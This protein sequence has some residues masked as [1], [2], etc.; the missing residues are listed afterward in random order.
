MSV[1]FEVYYPPPTDPRRE[2]EWRAVA[3]RHGGRLDF[4]EDDTARTGICLSYEFDDWAAAES[5]AA[6][7]RRH[8][9]HV[10]GP[11]EYAD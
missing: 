1:M 4:R 3:E 6:D 10:E 2:A 5:A 7:L 8:G 11:T 9:E